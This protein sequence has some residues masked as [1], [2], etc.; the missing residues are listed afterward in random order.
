MEKISSKIFHY[1]RIVRKVILLTEIREYSHVSTI[2]V[3]RYAEWQNKF[4]PNRQIDTDLKAT[5]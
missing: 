2:S 3:E 1:H 5:N 4:S